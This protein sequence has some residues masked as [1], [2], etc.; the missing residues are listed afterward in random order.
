M[1]T[2]ITLLAIFSLG[3]VLTSQANAEN[4]LL[5][6]LKEFAAHRKIAA[7][8]QGGVTHREIQILTLEGVP[9][10]TQYAPDDYE[11]RGRIY[12]LQTGQAGFFGDCDDDRSKRF[13]EHINW[14]CA[15]HMPFNPLNDLLN[16]FQRRAQR[17]RD[18]QG[19]CARTISPRGRGSC[20]TGECNDSTSC[21]QLADGEVKIETNAGSVIMSKEMVTEFQAFLEARQTATK[22]APTP[23]RKSA[24][25][26]VAKPSKSASPTR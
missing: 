5:S 23:A 7:A 12:R 11:T 15:T 19:A 1:M 8:N 13:N 25:R 9:R 17:I 10:T 20:K 22:N 2:R 18:G 3:A 21:S 6:T 14:K 26:T 24:T 4:R 16:D